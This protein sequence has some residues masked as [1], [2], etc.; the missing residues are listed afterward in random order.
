M[1]VFFDQQKFIYNKFLA[2]VTSWLKSTVLNIQFHISKKDKETVHIIIMGD[3][4]NGKDV[5]NLVMDLKNKIETSKST[6]IYY[7]AE[8]NFLY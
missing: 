4:K 1:E 5:Q 3:D 7:F 2:V 6:I 8:Y